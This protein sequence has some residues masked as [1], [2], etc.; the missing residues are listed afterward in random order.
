MLSGLV[1]L[2]ITLLIV[3]LIFSVIWWVVS[4][5]PWPAP[6]AWAAIVIKVIV[7]LILLIWLISVLLPM[8]GGGLGHPLFRY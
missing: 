7:A 6:F 2:L 3:G 1:G 4:V 8:A 5:I